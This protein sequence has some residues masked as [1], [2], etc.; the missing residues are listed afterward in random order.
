M[1]NLCDSTFPLLPAS[2]LH[3]I[4]LLACTAN[5]HHSIVM[6]AGYCIASFGFLWCSELTIPSQQEFD[7]EVLT[8]KLK[9][10]AIDKKVNHL[11]CTSL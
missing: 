6:W 10:I 9:D 2:W 1:G 5:D 3:S 8:I 11:L 7:L 4:Q